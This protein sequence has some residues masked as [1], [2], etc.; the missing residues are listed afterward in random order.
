[1]CTQV[2]IQGVYLGLYLGF[3]LPGVG[4]LCTEFFRVYFHVYDMKRL[5]RYA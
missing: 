1:M 3:W 2:H 5:I 4:F